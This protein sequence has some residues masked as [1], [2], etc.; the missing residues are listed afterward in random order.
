MV[1]PE[2]S[3]ITEPK[4]AFDGETRSQPQEPGTIKVIFLYTTCQNVAEEKALSSIR[5]P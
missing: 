2:N 3:A 1:G 4:L 5:F